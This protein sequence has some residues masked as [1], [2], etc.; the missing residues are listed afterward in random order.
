MS[1]HFRQGIKNIPEICAHHGIRKVIIAPGSR[2][3]P[4]IFAFTAQPEMECLSITD[5]RSA[6][7]FALG[8]ALQASE[9]VALVCTSGTAVLNFAP[10]IA[11]AYYQN[12]P[13]IVF[14]ADRP[15]EMIDQAD[16]Q[17]LRQTNIF[18]NYIKASFDL[19]VE[20]IID[21]DLDFSNRQ[22]SQAV[23]TALSYPQGPVQINVPMREPIYTALPET[24]SNPKIIKTIAAQT[25]PT[26][27]S[28]D[29]LQKSWNK[30]EKKMVVFGVYP[31]NEKLNKLANQLAN[32]PDVVV[33]CEN[34]SNIAGDKII[35][36]PESFFSS[37]SNEEKISFKPDLLIT[38]GH[39]VICKQLK[40]FLREQKPLEQWQFESSLPYIDTYKSLTTIIPGLAV[41]V[42]DEMP[43][44]KA[45][46]SF[47][48]KFQVQNQIIAKRHEAFVANAP[49]SD[50]IAVTKLLELAPENTTLHLANST[51][52]R[53]TQLFPT[54]SDIS[55][56]CNRGTSGID[57]SLSTAAGFAYVSKKPN[58]FL[59]GDLSFIYDS[60]GLWNNYIG[61]NIKIIVLNNNGGNIFRFIGDKQLMEKSL[62]FFTTPHKVKIKPLVEA[63]GLNYMACDKTESL[64]RT[65]KEFF[66]TEKATVLEIFTDSDLNTENY[67]E[68]FE[69][70]RTPNP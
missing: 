48:E 29:K 33:I 18:G 5:E 24:H 26:K 67:K 70:I 57:G 8:I 17:T 20:T 22:V 52:V 19:P 44:G 41:D 30:F 15:A 13:L 45:E 23:D 12:L 32:E 37:L 51:S 54:R 34:L 53:W 9:A 64:E 62:D 14:T 58:V 3:A 25:I 35:T 21:S 56:F 6:A 50:M 1:N 7:Y 27:E 65:M 36:R 42:L 11:E 47:S 49:I 60:N 66:S 16:G 55:Y 63:Y 10:A 31:K 2:N 38:I 68:Y 28:L 61:N 40:L 69:N 39:S 43:F 46:S 4:L 59:T